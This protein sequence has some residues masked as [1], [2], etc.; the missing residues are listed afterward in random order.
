[1]LGT[2]GEVGMNSQM[3]FFS[4]P[5]HMDTPVF[6]DQQKLTFITCA[7][8]LGAVWKTYEEQWMIGTD[9]EWESRETMQSAWFLDECKF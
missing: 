5:P 4:G 9:V 7:Q 2:I 6:A 3:K 1:M 8:T